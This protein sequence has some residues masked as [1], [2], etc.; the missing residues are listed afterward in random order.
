VPA[1]HAS[2][3]RGGRPALPALPDGTYAA[4]GRRSQGEAYFRTFAREHPEHP[5]GA[6]YVT[7]LREP[8]P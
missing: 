2:P 4:T 7:R 1:W 6:G 5:D 8:P 3:A